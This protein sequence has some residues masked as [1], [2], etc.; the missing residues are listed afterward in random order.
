M[1]H[2]MTGKVVSDKMTK[3]IVVLVSR[4]KEHPKY[5]RRYQVNKKYKAHDEGQACRI[6]DTVTIEEC[7]PISAD[8]K[9]RVV[10]RQA[11]PA[12]K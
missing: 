11:A 7:R 12:A 6:G 2:K 4:I 10:A 1:K 3:T 5:R 9:W 8:K